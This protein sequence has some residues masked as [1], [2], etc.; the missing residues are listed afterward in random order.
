MS[1]KPKLTENE[2]AATF[3]GWRPDLQADVCE[4][5]GAVSS[6]VPER[7]RF[8]HN[9]RL[10]TAVAAPD[11]TDPR[12]YMKAL[13]SLD[14]FILGIQQKTK[15]VQKVGILKDNYPL[16]ISS[17]RPDRTLGDL[18]ISFLSEIYDAEHKE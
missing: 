13:E 14:G 17:E 8:E 10:N 16:Q 1:D 18:V 3:I 12:N 4:L 5:C 9:F 6:D 2:R 15:F 11:L 7:F